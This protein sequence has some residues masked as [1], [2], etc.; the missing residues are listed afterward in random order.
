MPA[1]DHQ[2]DADLATFRVD[3]HPERDVVHV[4]AV[5]DL[6]LATV[7]QLRARISE[8]RDAGFKRLVLDLRQL[9][10]MDLRGVALILDEDRCAQR[11]GHAFSLIP[12]PAAV[13][14]VL[15]MCCAEDLLRLC[16]RP[17]HSRGC[18]HVPS[19]SDRDCRSRGEGYEALQPR[20]PAHTLRSIP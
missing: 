16:F 7:M 11:N 1:N 6:D 8:L 14:R 10:F 12:G 2:T 5:G 17:S 3:I 18:E 4:A 20:V 15:D 13:Q 19:S 9:T